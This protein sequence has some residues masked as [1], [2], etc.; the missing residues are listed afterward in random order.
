MA[1][2][3]RILFL[4]LSLGIFLFPQQILSA[5]TNE[6]HEVCCCSTNE[7]HQTNETSTEC[8]GTSCQD[9]T[10]SHSKN[11]SIY[12]LKIEDFIPKKT[13]LETEKFSLNYSFSLPKG[14]HSIWQPPKIN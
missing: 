7:E 9:C 14:S 5:Q 3:F 6:E 4:I 1:K 8:C 2:G 12:Y 10:I 11:F 13:F